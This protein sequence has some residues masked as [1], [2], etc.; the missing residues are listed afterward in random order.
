MAVTYDVPAVAAS[1]ARATSSGIANVQTL[2]PPAGTSACVLTV[3]TS[4]AQATFNGIDASTTN[5][6]IL[7]KDASPIFFPFAET[8][9]FVSTA[10]VNSVVDVLWL[11]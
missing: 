1:H 3:Q 9:K 8:I 10:A 11:D 6:I 7:Q 5:G 2:S 4:N